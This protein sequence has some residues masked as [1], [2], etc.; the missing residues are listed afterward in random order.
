MNP[1]TEPDFAQFC[2]DFPK[3]RQ[4]IDEAIAKADNP[5]VRK[6]LTSLAGTMDE[7][8][9]EL[10]VVYPEAWAAVDEQFQ[11][12][13]SR[14]TEAQ[15]GVAEVK[16]QMAA[17][18]QAQAEAEKAKAATKAAPAVKPVKAVD[19]KL[20]AVLRRELLDRF[21]GILGKAPEPRRP[22]IREAWEDWDWEA[23]KRN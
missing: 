23:W 5:A 14:V 7:K 11:K 3:F 10:K 6:Q 12:T 16:E 21:D 19:P 15:R 4:M 20:G 8:F 13:R 18:R 22:E 1:P 2:N 9:A 17:A